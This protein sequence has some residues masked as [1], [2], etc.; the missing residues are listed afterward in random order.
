MSTSMLTELAL[1][2]TKKR[3]RGRNLIGHRATVN[4]P[5]QRRGN[6]TMCAAILTTGVVAHHAVFGPYNTETIQLNS[7]SEILFPQV[8]QEQME[9]NF[10]DFWNNVQFH[11]SALVQELFEH[12]PHFP[13][14]YSFLHILLSWIQLRSY[15]L[16]GDGKCMI[17]ML[18]TKW[19]FFK[20]WKRAVEMLRQKLVNDFFFF[21]VAWILRIYVVM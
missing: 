9:H 15:S 14:S 10:V 6:I 2:S 5:G 20:Q 3:R 12:H 16:L 19:V 21:Y 1:I 4:V 13:D 11:Y 7:L 8:D 17:T 18:T